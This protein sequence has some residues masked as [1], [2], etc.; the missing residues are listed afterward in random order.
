M[1]GNTIG[2]EIEQAFNFESMES[3][4]ASSPEYQELMK[5]MNSLPAALRPVYTAEQPNQP[6]LLYEGDLKIAQEINQ[7]SVQIQGQGKVEYVWFPSPHIK[8]EFFNDDF[9]FPLD[10]NNRSA[11]LTL[12]NFEVSV[13]VFMERRNFGG[14]NG[15]NLS[16]RT[17]KPIVQGTDRDLV[18][19]IFHL[20]N[21]HNLIGCQKT[22]LKKD[23]GGLSSSLNRISFEVESWK[24]TLDRLETAKDTVEQL[25]A[26]G[27]FAI[28]HIGK[29]EKIDG[30]T[31]SGDEAKEFLDIFA[32]FLSFARGFRVPL[33]LLVGYDTRENK[34]WQYWDSSVGHSWRSVD[35]W[36]PTRDA[37]KLAE[38]FPGFM[39][40][41]QDWGESAKL[42]LYSYLE[43]NYTPTIE[44][45]TSPSRR[46]R[47]CSV[48]LELKQ[49][50]N[51]IS[52]QFIC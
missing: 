6:I 36:C 35:S 51:F 7:H 34:I 31:F 29:L 24:I 2:N 39:N 43:A 19:V 32:N 40:W 4:Q 28:T 18:Y 8:F 27:G 15:I 20:V 25:Q 44:I 9:S 5:Y 1:F 11:T 42:A 41:W 50:L 47:V 16:G 10:I 30:Q 22:L 49:K 13:D 33:V 21:F 38:I 17:Q 37:S 23:S 14:S 12:S 26:Q 48:V 52:S 46:N 45:Q 3:D